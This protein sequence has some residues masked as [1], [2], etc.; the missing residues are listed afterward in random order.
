ME[1]SL[2][3]DIRHIF[4]E[5]AENVNR[6]DFDPRAF[7]KT[8][9]TAIAYH[10]LDVTNEFIGD[11]R[12][13][14]NVQM[15]SLQETIMV[16]NIRQNLEERAIEQAHAISQTNLKQW[17]DS[18]GVVYDMD[19]SINKDAARVNVFRAALYGRL[20][21]IACYETQWCAEYT[22]INEVSY[23]VGI[24]GLSLKEADGT[25]KRWDAQGDD[26]MRRWHSDADSQ[27][28][29]V[30]DDFIVMGEL[31]N[32][33]GDRSRSSIENW[34]N[35]RCSAMYAT[36]R[37]LLTR[38]DQNVRPKIKKLLGLLGFGSRN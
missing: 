31:M 23:L 3:I 17:R 16:N 32:Y 22:K 34:I 9:E 21:A 6:R 38:L 20:N 36:K 25:T 35:C 12:T 1:R 37:S 26:K 7:D 2:L 18:L 30:D 33:P 8:I 27:V 29:P 11:F 5:M 28:V 24:D 15:D 14:H 10:Y 13:K 19:M 4:N